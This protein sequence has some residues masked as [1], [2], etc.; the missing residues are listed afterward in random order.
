MKLSQPLTFRTSGGQTF[1]A[2]SPPLVIFDDS[3]VIRDFVSP[4]SHVRDES[5][6]TRYRI[7]RMRLVSD[8][9][10]EIILTVDPEP[11]PPTEEE[12]DKLN[13]SRTF[14]RNI[15]SKGQPFKNLSSGS[16]SK[17]VLKDGVYLFDLAVDISPGQILTNDLTGHNFICAEVR[18]NQLECTYA[19]LQEY[20]TIADI[21]RYSDTSQDSFG[22]TTSEQTTVESSLPIIFNQAK[23]VAAVQVGAAVLPGDT[24]FI[25]ATK[26]S[27]V[28]LT[29]R[30]NDYPGL[31]NLV[32][33]RLD[34][35]LS[36]KA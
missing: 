11:E 29:T 9:M 1:T 27:Y 22:H 23:N 5:T 26:E 20:S 28:V 34:A 6:N 30:S 12:L 4:G 24:L 25:Q 3:E 33:Q 21:K 14:S 17:G 7:G 36:M 35:N 19:R 32:V 15:S 13:P 2:K 18:R 16:T 10:Y 31:K 8:R